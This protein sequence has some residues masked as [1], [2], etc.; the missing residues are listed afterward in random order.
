[1]LPMMRNGLTGRFHSDVAFVYCG[2]CVAPFIARS[3][4][5]IEKNRSAHIPNPGSLNQYA[6]LPE[7]LEKF[8]RNYHSL[9]L[10]GPLDDLSNLCFAHQRLD[11]I[12]LTRP[13]AAVYLN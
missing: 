8:S 4:P 12:I 2:C 5:P 11:R 6:S 13:I 10:I 3:G 7:L 1:M 9:N